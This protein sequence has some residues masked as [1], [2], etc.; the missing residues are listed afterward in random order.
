MWATPHWSRPGTRRCLG[1]TRAAKCRNRPKTKKVLSSLRGTS[2][3]VHSAR[4]GWQRAPCPP[5]ASRMVYKRAKTKSERKRLWMG[6]WARPKPLLEVRW[7]GNPFAGTIY[8]YKVKVIYFFIC[9]KL[10]NI[11]ISQRR[12]QSYTY[13]GGKNTQPS[14]LP[15]TT[16]HN[17][18]GLLLGFLGLGP[19]RWFAFLC[20]FANRQKI[21]A[22]AI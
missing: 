5:R 13:V 15:H 21:F 18:G 1:S 6:S 20:N 3:M 9:Y 8:V 7:A 10:L 2:E 4:R 11:L 14:Q 19:R 17:I 12:R 22:W 16:I